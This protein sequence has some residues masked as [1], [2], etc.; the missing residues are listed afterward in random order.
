MT[1][2]KLK[3]FFSKIADSKIVLNIKSKKSN[4]IKKISSQDCLHLAY[5]LIIIGVLFDLFIIATGHYLI[6]VDDSYIGYVYSAIITISI[7]SFTLLALLSGMLS[8]RYYGYELKDILGFK[9][10][11]VNLQKFIRISVS[12]VVFATILLS[13]SYK[14]VCVNTL[15]FLLFSMTFIVMNTGLK[16]YRIMTDEKYCIEIVKNYYETLQ[17]NDEIN[18]NLLKFHLEK[19]SVA[20]ETAIKDESEENVNK[21]M[22]MMGKLCAFMKKRNQDKE[23]EIYYVFLN[24]VI[25]KY[26][27][28]LS[29]H[30][31]YNQMIRKVVSLYEVLS[32]N[33]FVRNDLILLPIK[34]MQ[35]YS[36]KVLLNLK[37]LYEIMDLYWLDEYEKNKIKNS[38]IQQILDEYIFALSQNQLCSI[39]CK[40][41]MISDYI[42]KL[43]R[44]TWKSGSELLQVDQIALLKV[45][46]FYI[47]ENENIDERE[48]IF[49][50][51]VKNTCIRNTNSN[52]KSYYNYLSII[53]QAFYAYIFLERETLTSKYREYLKQLFQIEV[54]S[55][56][57]MQLNLSSLI[58]MNIKGILYSVASRIE[59]K[60]EFTSLFAYKFCNR[61]FRHTI[62]TNQF[63]IQF[64]FLLYVL[65]NK[66]VGFY[67]LYGSFFEWEHL[68]KDMK[69]TILNEFMSYFNYKTGKIRIDIFNEV[70]KLA[71]LMKHPFSINDNYESKLFLYI[72]EEFE[73]LY[74]E[75]VKIKKSHI[76][77]LKEINQ[78]LIELM[79]R[80][81]VYGWHSDFKSDFNIKY[82]SDDNICRREELD[83]K[84]AARRIQTMAL[85]TLNNYIYS[86]TNELEISFDEQGIN[87]MLVFLNNCNYDSKNYTYTNDLAFSKE[88]RG[89]LC[90]KEVV[91]KEAIINN[92]D[93]PKINLSIYF[94]KDK[95]KFN[96]YIC[97]YGHEDLTDDECVEYIKNSKAYNGLYNVDGALMIKDKA[98]NA[99]KELFVR[100]IIEIR[101]IVAFKHADITHVKYK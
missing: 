64:I 82:K 55:P 34:E 85:S 57:N 7:L 35:F 20:L 38:E 40:N 81:N 100:E 43:S 67:S 23:Y 49:K 31:G 94:N 41:K 46:K 61:Q 47:I 74:S 60:D 21:S 92:V 33:E 17:N 48:F 97:D 80:D 29:L 3:K 24:S 32:D 52:E 71:E 2:L 53:C 45:L 9:N 12:Y 16:I 28:Q 42:Y 30:F 86:L 59:R 63:D 4:I 51:L 78:H 87:K 19:L 65:Y 13:L 69:L 26:V 73:K 93:T 95:F 88:V 91:I 84:K 98:I 25:K 36:D 76:L 11:P 18:Y 8:T 96:I 1:T 75:K 10:A 56:N 15:V 101:L 39:K 50:E 83:N 22:E 44:F 6:K 89:S 70:A 66:N 90:F 27:T 68:D 72:N 58:K 37:Y 79:I 14:V 99:I 5:E 62:W 77:D 54:E